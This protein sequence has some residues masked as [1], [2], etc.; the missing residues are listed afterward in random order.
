MYLIK[1]IKYLEPLWWSLFGLG[2]AIAAFLFPAHILIQ[3]VLIPAGILPG[4]M[5]QYENFAGLLSS[6]VVK[7]YFLALITF[8]LYHAAHR[9]RMTLEDLRIE[10]LSS[11]LPLLCYGGASIL[12]VFA[13]VVIL[14][15]P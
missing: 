2:G 12:A 5:L 9:I 15:L 13:V 1:F 6:P 14:R 3:G 10:W 11:L 8:P 4:D 7:I